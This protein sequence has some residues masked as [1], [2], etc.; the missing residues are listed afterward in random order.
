[1]EANASEFD[2]ADG[3][4][5]FTAGITLESDS[6]ADAF[7]ILDALD[8]GLDSAFE[9][10]TPEFDSVDASSLATGIAVESSSLDVES[11]ASTLAVAFESI[12]AVAFKTLRA[13]AFGTFEAVSLVFEFGFEALFVVVAFGIVACD[14]PEFDSSDDDN[15]KGSALTLPE[16]L[17]TSATLETKAIVALRAGGFDAG[18]ASGVGSFVTLKNSSDDAIPELEFSDSESDLMTCVAIDVGFEGGG[19]LHDATLGTNAGVAVFCGTSSESVASDVVLEG[20]KSVEDNLEVSAELE[21]RSCKAKNLNG[22][23]IEALNLGVESHT[24]ILNCVDSETETLDDADSEAATFDCTDS[25]AKILNATAFESAK[26]VNTEAGLDSSTENFDDLDASTLG[27]VS[28]FL[29][30]T[31]LR[32]G[33]ETFVEGIF[34][35]DSSGT[36]FRAAN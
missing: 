36:D 10:N 32:K 25:L 13:L 11:R 12:V 26:L 24:S 20:D 22:V 23:A 30:D 29:V 5:E 8:F 16:G 35:T 27:C 18:V 1:M 14:I 31:D 15:A 21:N 34:L 7:E 28:K 19:A 17:A 9:A 4:S 2:S 6:L 3:D 33:N